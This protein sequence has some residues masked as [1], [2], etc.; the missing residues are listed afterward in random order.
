MISYELQ[1]DLAYS[2]G[3]TRRAMEEAERL[4]ARAASE[5]GDEHRLTKLLFSYASLAGTVDGL[6]KIIEAEQELSEVIARE[7][8]GSTLVL[9]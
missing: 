9:L 7:N 3:L 4:Y 8:A 6:I 5:L 1:R 2:S